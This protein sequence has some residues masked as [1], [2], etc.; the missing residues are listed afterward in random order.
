MHRRPTMSEYTP[1]KF[2]E[3]YYDGLE[4]EEMRAI[5]SAWEADRKRIE[6]LERALRMAQAFVDAPT[7]FG[8]RHKAYMQMRR[9]LAALRE[10]EET[11]REDKTWHLLQNIGGGIG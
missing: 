5:K 10:V 9:A 7:K 4:I 11:P 2:E 6:A 8:I 3:M 1:E